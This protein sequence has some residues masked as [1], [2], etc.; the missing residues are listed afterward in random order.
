VPRQLFLPVV[1]KVDLIQ[2][3]S[4]SSSMVEGLVVFL[5]LAAQRA[6]LCICHLSSLPDL[7]AAAPLPGWPSVRRRWPLR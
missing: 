1:A 3:T 5:F 4:T 7:F 2:F 6:C